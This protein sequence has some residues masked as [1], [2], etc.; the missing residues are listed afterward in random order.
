MPLSEERA[1][2]LLQAYTQHTATDAEEEELLQWVTA[3]HDEKIL[4]RYIDRLIRA[5]EG[6]PLAEPDWEKT[7]RK[8]LRRSQQRRTRS[9]RKGY[10]V[11]ATL[12]ALVMAGG[13]YLLYPAERPAADRPTAA[14]I[15]PG[16]SKAFLQAGDTRV[17]L[18]KKDTSFTLAGNTIQVNGGRIRTADAHPVHYVLTTPRGGEYRV[19]LA[20]GTAVWMNAASRLEYPSV[21]TGETR[22]V[23]LE[24]EAFFAVASDA[25]H[26]FIVNTPGQ[27]IRVLGTAF[28][29]HAYTDEK[30]TVT[31]LVQ[32]S[33][34]VQSAAHTL[35]LKPG[36][37]SRLDGTGTLSRIPDADTGAAVAWKN[38]YFRFA[39]A[40]IHTI[41]QQL[42]RWYDVTVR[43]EENL[44]ER[45]FG[46][47][48]RRDNDIA[49]VLDILEAT[50]GIRFKTSGKEITVMP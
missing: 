31:T 18:N 38:G 14:A 22:Q 16:S 12:L 39:G 20:D 28:N 46:A 2:Y 49:Q 11:A 13:L 30:A 1:Y 33:V 7:Y 47:I 40:D 37:Q 50:G 24:G 27:S 3:A 44:P 19:V 43:Y 15:R 5:G 17:M 8:I 32:G 9:L 48:I 36:E 4:R 45:Y 29:V 34:A 10:A 42:S 21:F 25:G 26:P 23:Q 35:R 41:M 6:L